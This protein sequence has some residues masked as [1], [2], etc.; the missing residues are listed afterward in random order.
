M[1][2]PRIIMPDRNVDIPEEVHRI[3]VVYPDQ[4]IYN[5]AISGKSETL[6]MHSAAFATVEWQ[7]MSFANAADYAL[8]RK[9]Q[10]WWQHAKAGGQWS[11]ARD[12][13]KVVHTTLASNASA[14]ASSIVV[15]S[16]TG[17]VVGQQYVLRGQYT[18]LVEVSSIASAPTIALT[19]PLLFEFDTLAV[20][21]DEYYLFGEVLD[22]TAPP[23]QK[24]LPDHYHVTLQF[25]ESRL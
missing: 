16:A 18:Q 23:I 7:W 4:R 1:G 12:R 14:G 19:E 2:L 21:R 10:Q 22:A 3:E 8:H 25:R 5:V 17:I 11:F 9:L 15:T 6:T 24:E 20:F 13:D